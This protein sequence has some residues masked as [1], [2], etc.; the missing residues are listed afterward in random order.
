MEMSK[1]LQVV[2]KVYTAYVLEFTLFCYE[3]H[4]SH[5]GCSQVNAFS[6][7]SVIQLIVL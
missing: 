3:L 5:M 7:L 4:A 2:C 1:F 6:M